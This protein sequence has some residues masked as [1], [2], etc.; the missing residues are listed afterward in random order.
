MDTASGGQIDPPLFFDADT[1][2]NSNKNP[3]ILKREKILQQLSPEVRVIANNLYKTAYFD[4][5]EEESIKSLYEEIIKVKQSFPDDMDILNEASKLTQNIRRQISRKND[6]SLTDTGPFLVILEGGNK[7]NLGNLH[8]MNLAKTIHQKNIQGVVNVSRKGKNRVGIE[9][10]NATKAND[11]IKNQPFGNENWKAFIPQRLVSITGIIRD[12]GDK[13]TEEDIHQHGVAQIRT[14]L[15]KEHNVKILNVQRLKRRVKDGNGSRL[16]F[17]N[18]MKITF[19]GKKLPQELNYFSVKREISPFI[20][21]VILCYKCCRFGHHKD[22]CR[23]KNRCLFCTEEHDFKTCPNKDNSANHKCV[24]CQE[25]HSASSKSCSEFL[26]QKALNE[27]MARHNISFYE[28]TQLIPKNK[29]PEKRNS[30][31]MLNESAFPELSPVHIQ[32]RSQGTPKTNRDPYPTYVN[33]TKKRRPSSPPQTPGYNKEAHRECL[34][35]SVNRIPIPSISS[36][37][38]YSSDNEI[39]T[40]L[41]EAS[42]QRR[43]MEELE[44]KLFNEFKQVINNMSSPSIKKLNHIKELTSR[45]L[46]QKGQFSSQSNLN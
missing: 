4:I 13:I 20:N 41:G 9:F 21:R 10:T 46:I 11:F 34:F 22:Q 12:V 31:L 1:Q 29:D 30:D 19:E 18:I 42:N 45:L 2:N 33:V 24:N 40:P 15:N 16:E 32:A 36:R 7:E 6:Y 44:E 8:P 5:P 23:G 3:E 37:D 38:D 28:A 43:G 26:R 17:T 25:R 39:M 35:P 27:L 14:I